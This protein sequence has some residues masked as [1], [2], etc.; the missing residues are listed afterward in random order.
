M[1]KDQQKLVGDVIPS[2]ITVNGLQRVLQN[3]LN[4]RVSIRDL[5]TIIEGIAEASGL[6]R[7]LSSISEH[8]RS[9][10]SRQISDASTNDM[11]YIPLLTLSPEW[12]QTFIESL[13]GDGDDKRLAL[14]PSKLQQFIQAVRQAYDKFALTGESPV[15]LTSPTIRPFVRSIMERFRPLTTVL[16]QNEIHPKAKIKTLGQI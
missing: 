9:R 2:L 4:E 5:P 15:L 7:N 14:P 3:L 13:A 1:G 8:V 6:T 11:G 16:S 12:E 10:L